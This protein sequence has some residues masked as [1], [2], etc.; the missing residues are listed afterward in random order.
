MK[1]EDYLRVT[2]L[3]RDNPRRIRMLAASNRLLTALVFLSYPAFL[4]RLLLQRDPLLPRAVI[5]P[6]ASF[7]AVSALR[8]AIN[9]PRPYERFGVPPVLHKETRGKSFPSRH[10]F[11]AFAIAS[12]V[13][14]KA[15]AAGTALGAAGA[16][17]AA[18]RVIGG[19][20]SPSDVLAGAA[21]GIACRLFM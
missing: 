10:V 8:A 3:V 14:A 21:L 4:L 12:A 11:S 9:A 15:P 19:V 2:G 16:A 17:L 7:A 6:A 5:V 13:S 1:K 20:H 18:I